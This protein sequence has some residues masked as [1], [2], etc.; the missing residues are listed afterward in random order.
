MPDLGNGL[1]PFS[2]CILN[3]EMLKVYFALQELAPVNQDIH[4]YD[5]PNCE[6]PFSNLSRNILFGKKALIG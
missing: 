3:F 4:T 6:S 1:S 5:T 2:L